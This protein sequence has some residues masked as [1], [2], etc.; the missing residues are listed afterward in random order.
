VYR[1]PRIVAAA[2]GAA[3]VTVVMIGVLASIPASGGASAQVTL[4]VAPRA[5]LEAG[6][7][8]STTTP[9]GVDLDNPGQPATTCA[10]KSTETDACHWGF[11][12]GTAVRLNA[13]ASGGGYAFAGWSTPE[14]PGTGSCTVTLDDDSTSIVALFTPLRLGVKFSV[15]AVLP[16]PL[17]ARRITSTPGGIDCT[18]DGTDGDG[19]TGCQHD[20]ALN[21]S[22]QLT[23]TGDN[24]T[25]WSGGFCEPATARTC[26][27]HVIDY[28]SWAGAVFDSEPP[29][30]LATTIKVRFHLGKG[31]NGSGIVTAAGINCGS[32]CSADFGYGDKIVLTATATGDSVFD[33]W[34][35]V[36]ART[37]RTCSFAVGPITRIKALFARDTTPP[38]APSDLRTTRRTRTEIALA[39]RASTDNIRVKGYRVYVD[40]T[41][42][43]DPTSTKYTVTDLSC[44][45]RYRLAVDSVDGAGNR[46]PRAGIAARAKLCALL[47]RLG[48][49]L[50][51][52]RHR[53]RKVV[54]G[55]QVNR[56]TR[57]TL[58]LTRPRGR[59]PVANARFRLRPG[60]NVLR[61]PVRR[62]VAAGSYRLGIAVVDPDGGRPHVLMR[63][64]R[65][66]A[67]R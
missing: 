47:V 60:R 53:A 19:L 15:P 34:N 48:R 57:A 36:C 63:R 62:R 22:V 59:R 46:S 42:V 39:W 13:A 44:G 64:V 27:I 2:F 40:D 38:T 26:T 17:P 45:H 1:V 43:A 7:T 32:D 23:A 67:P 30:Q 25:Q 20:F 51:I 29:P 6:A 9:G 5:P 56:V 50:V 10:G 35:G 3:A 66:P 54:V 16:D 41:Q 24:F 65:L 33:G 58:T 18:F 14:C 8:V 28:T 37:Q 55:L 49:V 61:L 4:Q 52:H 31:G 11:P 21:S 12:A